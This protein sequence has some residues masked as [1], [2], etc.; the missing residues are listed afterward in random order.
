MNSRYFLGLIVLTIGS[1]AIINHPILGGFIVGMT[2]G[3]AFFF[4]KKDEQ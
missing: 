2:Y 3:W 4:G 1:M